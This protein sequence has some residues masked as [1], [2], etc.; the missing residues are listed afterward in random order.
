MAAL[1]EPQRFKA[2]VLI[3]PSPCYV[4]DPDYEGGFE[5]ADLMALLTEMDADYVPWARRLAPLL[6]GQP[7]NLELTGS[8]EE[9]FCRC[10]PS[11]A[12]HFG[13]VSYLADLRPL[14][15]RV[16][17]P[18]LIM[19]CRDDPLVP[20]SVGDYVQ[21]ALPKSRLVRLDVPG[22]CPH[23]SAPQKVAEEMGAFLASLV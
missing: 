13:R 15:S 17:L 5:R 1:C 22:H 10:D 14:L 4:N 16:Q 11:V 18:T 6:M 12:Q 23:L 20:S 9:R 19:Q 2:L 21:A 7:E 8:L 3:V